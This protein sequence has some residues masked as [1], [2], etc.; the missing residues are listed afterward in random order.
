[1]ARLLPPWRSPQHDGP[2]RRRLA[3]A[4]S[5]R[6]LSAQVRG[7]VLHDLRL[8]VSL[9]RVQR[10]RDHRQRLPGKAGRIEP[11][12]LNRRSG[13]LRWQLD[14][15]RFRLLSHLGE[16]LQHDEVVGRTDRQIALLFVVIVVHGPQYKTEQQNTL[17]VRQ[18]KQ[19]LTEP[20]R[21]RTD[22]R[23]SPSNLSW[24]MAYDAP[25]GGI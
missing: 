5:P 13:R 16:A 21:R 20:T 17:S 6:R 10:R 2:Q 3:V 24:P 14:D 18:A 1:M 7:L 4:R 12:Q 23:S 9:Q 19:R 22:T 15:L 25:G 8:D 11:G